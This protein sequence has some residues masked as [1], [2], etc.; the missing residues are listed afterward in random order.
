MLTISKR[1]WAWF[2]LLVALVISS[3]FIIYRLT[4]LQPIP[5]EVALGTLMDCI[6]ILPLLAY[7][8]IIRKRFSIKYLLLIS[9]VGYGIASL[10]IPQGLLSSYSFVKY[11]VF[12]GEGAFILLELY[13]IYKFI[14]KLPS[15]IRSLRTN[16]TNIPNFQSQLAHTIHQHFKLKRLSNFLSFDITLFYYSLFSWRKKPLH[17]EIRL[18]SFHKQ[19]SVIA[20]YVFL[21]HALIVESIAFHF[22]LHSW[23]QVVAIVALILNIYALLLLLAEIQAIRLCP[24]LITNDHVYLQV[25]IM[26]QLII[27]LKEI[28]SVHYY[29]GPE[30]LSSN[31]KKYIFDAVLADFTKEKPTFEVE[32][33]TPLEAKLLYGFKKKVIKAHIRP[34][35]PQKFYHTLC[36]KIKELNN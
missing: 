33:H 7:F 29:Q 17:D 10:I 25:G 28:K 20:F 16:E 1:K 11:I 4:I 32:F 19:T 27:P 26:K 9:I 13:I 31:E 24:F 12:A 36:T 30:K 23:N 18:F 21:I 34:D 5:K 6:I 8:F 22:L 2:C 3:N 35:E 15:I 14:T